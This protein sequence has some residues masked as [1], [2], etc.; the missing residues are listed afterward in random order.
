MT[1]EKCDLTNDNE[2]VE[3]V[4]GESSRELSQTLMQLGDMVINLTSL[5]VGDNIPRSWFAR[6]IRPKTYVLNP[7][8]FYSILLAALNRSS[9]ARSKIERHRTDLIDKYPE[10]Y[11]VPFEV[12]SGKIRGIISNLTVQTV[13]PEG[14]EESMPVGIIDT[15]TADRLERELKDIGMILHRIAGAVYDIEEEEVKETKKEREDIRLRRIL[16]IIKDEYKRTGRGVDYKLLAARTGLSERTVQR[17]ARRL[18]ELGYVVIAKDGN[19]H[20]LLPAEEGEE[21]EKQ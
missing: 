5:I 9:A 15:Y 8:E 14:S 4:L 7:G 21:G 11:T 19:R 12:L 2:E 6:Y 1:E 20:I 10:R 13:E 3:D 17:W 18:E 16:F